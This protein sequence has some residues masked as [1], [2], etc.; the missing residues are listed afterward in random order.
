MMKSC[1]KNREMKCRQRLH[2]R[3]GN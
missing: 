1:V 2:C 3:L